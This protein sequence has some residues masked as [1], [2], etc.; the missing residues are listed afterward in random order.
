[1]RYA[2][3][4]NGTV[5]NIV[6]STEAL[7][8]NWIRSDSAGIGDTYE[9]DQFTTPDPVTQVPQEVPMAA[10]RVALIENDLIDAVESAIAGI[11]D[12]KT[13]AKATAWWEYSATIRRDSPWIEMLAAAVPLSAEQIDAL[14][15]EAG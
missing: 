11:E 9:N 1:M 5:T 12:A 13:K 4:Q 7:A 8:D 10:A 14:F 3:V 15:V 2:I 6:K